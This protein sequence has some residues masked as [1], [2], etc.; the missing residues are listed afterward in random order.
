ML[1]VDGNTHAVDLHAVVGTD[2]N[3]AGLNALGNTWTKESGKLPMPKTV[4]DTFGA[5]LDTDFG[6]LKPAVPTVDDAQPEET[7]PFEE[8]TTTVDEGKKGCRSSLTAVGIISVLGV[9]L[10]AAACYRRKED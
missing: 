5:I 3:V 1:L 7:Q 4:K 10:G 2:E 9:T 8:D 6:K